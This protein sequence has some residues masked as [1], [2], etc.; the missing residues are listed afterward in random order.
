[1]LYLLARVA[2]APVRGSIGKIKK[3]R[4]SDVNP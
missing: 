1:M 3:A 4:A 2:S